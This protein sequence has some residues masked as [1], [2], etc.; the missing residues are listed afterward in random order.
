MTRALYVSL[1]L[2]HPPAFRRQFAPEMLWIFD[3]ARISEGVFALLLDIVVSLFR[4]WFLRAGL[5]KIATAMLGATLQVAPALWMGSRPRSWPIRPA[6]GTPIQIEGFVAI[7]VCMIAFV[8][9]MV[10]ASVFWATW[11]SRP[12]KLAARRGNAG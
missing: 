4:Q 5:W 2:L 1:L 11:V 9:F 8:V 7:T 10:V 12:K 3:E 6:T